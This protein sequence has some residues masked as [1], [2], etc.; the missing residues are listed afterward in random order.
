MSFSYSSHWPSCP[1]FEKPCLFC[2][3]HCNFRRPLDSS[4]SPVRWRWLELSPFSSSSLLCTVGLTLLATAPLPTSR[5]SKPGKSTCRLGP[6]FPGTLTLKTC[7][8]SRRLSFSIKFRDLRALPLI[9]LVVGLT[10]ASLMAESCSGMGT[11]GLILLILRPT[12]PNFSPSL[13]SQ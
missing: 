2:A 13:L 6:M 12:G 11:L 3:L 5:S 8:R 4:F 1:T 7:C 9:L 10:R